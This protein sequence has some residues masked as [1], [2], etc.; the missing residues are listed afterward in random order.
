M[1]VM[2]DTSTA[3]SASVM[4][5]GPAGLLLGR[6]Q[7]GPVTVRLFRP[8]PTRAFLSAP[9]WVK[10][11]IAFRAV[12]LGG[13]VS[14]IAGDHRP[15]LGLADTIRACGGTIDL[16]RSADELPGQG[17]VYRPSLIIDEQGAVTPQMRLGAWQAL[18]T[19]SNPAAEA[20]VSDMRNSDMSIIVPAEGRTSENLRRAYA[21]SPAQMKQATNLGDSDV[22][23]ASVRRLV[24]VSMPPSPTEYRVLF[25][26]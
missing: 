17:R 10:W 14:V 16:L 20:S 1:T 6:G 15:W 4:S 19:A 26:R 2:R 24:K 22:V 8:E 12:C 21:L 9:E 3:T 5:S 18:V 7:G 25:G 11:L 23:C 13:H